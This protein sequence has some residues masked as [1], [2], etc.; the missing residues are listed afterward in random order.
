MS[1]AL[2]TGASGFV[3]QTLLPMLLECGVDEFFLVDRRA[4]P[5]FLTSSLRKDAV[6]HEFVSDRIPDTTAV[7][8]V[9]LAI[10]LAGTTSVDAAL[11]E[12][13]PAMKGN[14]EL[15][16]DLAEW[17]WRT[18]RD[19]RVVYMSSDEVLGPSSKPLAED[20]PMKPSQPYAA[21][22]AAAEFIL[23]NYRDVYGINLVTLRS[24]NLVGAGQREPKLLPVCVRSI[25]SKEPVPIHGS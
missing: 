13:A 20:A 16:I 24:C 4:I 23:H 11:N 9:E 1:S 8:A 10:C 7:A 18:N 25:L 15:A 17:S 19:R 3:S 12:P 22:K 14:T 6:V 5:Q 21:S 2:I